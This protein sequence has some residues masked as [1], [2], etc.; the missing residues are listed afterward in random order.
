VK[1]PRWDILTP[2][3]QVWEEGQE[4]A[5]RGQ[6]DER[7][8]EVSERLEIVWSVIDFYEIAVLRRLP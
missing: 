8:D 5:C 4:V 7:A 1:W 6:D 2:R 3:E